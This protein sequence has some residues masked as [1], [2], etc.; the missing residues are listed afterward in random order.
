MPR[1]GSLR[2]LRIA[3]HF[4]QRPWIGR[5]MA[6]MNRE[7]KMLFH[8]HHLRTDYS[9]VVKSSFESESVDIDVNRATRWLIASAAVVFV[10][11][12]LAYQRVM[13]HRLWNV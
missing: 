13:R 10:C 4:L 1:W 9:E 12:V 11:G 3:A 7:M 5:Q 2:E 6:G 8:R